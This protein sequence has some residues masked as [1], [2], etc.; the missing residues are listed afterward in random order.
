MLVERALETKK[1]GAR[2]G[3]AKAKKAQ[4]EADTKIKA[5]AEL[6]L[7]IQDNSTTQLVTSQAVTHA[8][9]VIKGEALSYM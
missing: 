8:V 3:V 7:N 9:M 1:H 4:R 6:V 2:R 5:N